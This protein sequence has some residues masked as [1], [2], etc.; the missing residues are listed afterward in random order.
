MHNLLDN[1]F[2]YTPI[3]GQIRIRSLRAGDHIQ[4]SVEDNGSGIPEEDLPHVFERFYR[5]DKARSRKYGGTGLGLSIVKHIVTL[6]GGT[7]RAESTLG[8]ST[9]I[10]LSLPLSPPKAG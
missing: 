1:A 6:H 2:K 10:I 9:R 8:M 5:V 3:E 4:I 7:V